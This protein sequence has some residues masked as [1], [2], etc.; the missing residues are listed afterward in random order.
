MLSD[1]QELQSSD[2]SLWHIDLSFDIETR[3]EDGNEL[4]H[5]TYTFSYAKGWDKWTFKEYHEERTDDTTRMSDRNWKRARHIIWQDI[6]E[7]RTIDV[8]PEV[9]DALAEATGSESVTIQVPVGG[10]D[11]NEYKEIHSTEKREA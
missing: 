4:V 9:A 3:S 1:L 6:N 7:T 10:I 8:P 2:E 11:K 5:K